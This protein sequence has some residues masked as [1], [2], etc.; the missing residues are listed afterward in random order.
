MRIVHTES[1]LGWGG[2]EI[3]ILS[4]SKGLIGRRHDVT[5]LCPAE[6]RLFEEAPAWG[7]PAVAVPIAKKRP[8]G[9]RALLDWFRR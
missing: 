1:S 5:V 6:A 8:R 3:R 2:Q 7:V 4:E 9:L